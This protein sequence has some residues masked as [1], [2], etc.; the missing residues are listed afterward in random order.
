MGHR[1]RLLVDD[2]FVGNGIFTDAHRAFRAAG[3]DARVVRGAAV[4]IGKEVDCDVMRVVLL[5]LC[6]FVVKRR[7]ACGGC[8]GTRRRGRPW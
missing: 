7:K 8:L 1:L 3:C 6:D 5:G 4:G 2:R